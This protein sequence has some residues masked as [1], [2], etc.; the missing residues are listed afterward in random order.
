MWW[1]IY[2]CPLPTRNL[3][4]SSFRLTP[5][6]DD[7][8]QI[9]FPADQ[10][11]PHLSESICPFESTIVRIE[12][13]ILGLSLVLLASI[14]GCG[15]GGPELG[16]VQGRVTLDGKP[17]PNATL[18][19]IPQFE[20][21]P[22]YGVTDSNGSYTLAF[23][24]TKNG[25]MLGSFDVQIETKKISKQ[26]MSDDAQGEPPPFIAIPKKYRGKAFTAEVKRGS[27]E[28]NFEMQSN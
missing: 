9:Y 12:N 26:E 6:H 14:L 15:D 5:R 24:D 3:P 27:N 11:D 28:C 18:T 7:W 21:S 13:R 23:T 22:S 17:V 8:F 16:T 10:N 4:R 19:F 20:G 2:F 25:A 1:Q